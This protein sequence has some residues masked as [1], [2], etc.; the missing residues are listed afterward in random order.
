LWNILSPGP[1]TGPRFHRVPGE[2]CFISGPAGL[3]SIQRLH[4]PFKIFLKTACRPP[5]LPS[6]AHPIPRNFPSKHLGINL[7]AKPPSLPLPHTPDKA[8]HTNCTAH[9]QCKLLTS[10]LSI[11]QLQTHHIHIH[12]HTHVHKYTNTHICTYAYTQTHIHSLDLNPQHENWF[13]LLQGDPSSLSLLSPTLLWN[14]HSSQMKWRHAPNNPK[15]GLYLVYF[16]ISS[17]L[18][19]F[20]YCWLC[21]CLKT[22]PFSGSVSESG[23]CP[24]LQ[25]RKP[26]CNFKFT[27]VFGL[28]QANMGLLP[29]WLRKWLYIV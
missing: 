2:K 13:T 27:F 12:V 23:D 18:V 1:S 20:T 16:Q 8:F 5:H 15:L 11:V 4:P 7:L 22:T 17:Y 14:C 26:I 24:G 28:S 3:A 19:L 21:K 29:I 10:I 9:Y 25:F 6:L